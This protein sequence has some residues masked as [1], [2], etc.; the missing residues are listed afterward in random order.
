M[1]QEPAR[2]HPHY[3]FKPNMATVH[4]AMPGSFGFDAILPPKLDIGAKSLFFQPPKTPSASTSLAILDVSSST[5]RKRSR[6]DTY[7]HAPPTSTTQATTRSE[8]PVITPS[9]TPGAMSPAPLVDSRYFLAGGLDTPT[10]AR[11][12][13]MDFGENEYRATPN[14]HLRGGRGI[15]GFNPSSESYFPHLPSALARE[16]NGRARL[17]RQVGIRDGVGKIVYTFVGVA[18]KVLQFC[19]TAAFN[20][21]YAGGGQ[22]Y[23]MK[24][25]LQSLDGGQSMWQ[26]METD[27][28]SQTWDAEKSLLPGRFPDEDFYPN[29]MSQDH[30]TPPRASKK[31]Q[32]E[33]ASGEVSASWVVV[34]S[35]R[36]SR[37]SSPTRLSH[38]KSPLTGTF[39]RKP[40]PRLGRRPIL[41]ASRPLLT[42]YAG[43]PGVHSNGTASFASPRSLTSSPK[44]ESPGSI[45]VQRHAARMRRREMEEDANLKKFNNQLQA[46]IKEGKQAL[47][48]KFE[49]EINED[50]PVDEGF[51]EGGYFDNRWKG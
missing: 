25:P 15:E 28:M 17:Q 43:S 37:E 35:N 19:K 11:S 14:L 33:T 39:A 29:Y 10:A 44:H 36:S 27:D 5:S 16:G 42:S 3:S 41:P 12:S 47:G 13:L 45:E 30:T 40:I 20:G 18:G 34:G 26:D 49:V 50:E 46:M 8:M 38:R 9:E 22:G 31:I 1:G 24:P 2:R 21:F 51:G 7:D 23:D 48:T 4:A 32:R 6:H